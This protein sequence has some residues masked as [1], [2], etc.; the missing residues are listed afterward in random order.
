V[1]E[2]R[3]RFSMRTL[4]ACCLLVMLVQMGLVVAQ[5]SQAAKPGGPPAPP[6]AAKLPGAGA[7]GAPGAAGQQGPP[8]SALGYVPISRPFDNPSTLTQLTPLI[9]IVPECP[10]SQTTVTEIQRMR[11]TA[12]QI[13]QMIEAEVQIMTKR[14][15]YVEQMSSYLNDRIRELNKVKSELAQETHWLEVSSSRIEEL[16]QREKLVR[17]QDVLTC[18]NGDQSKLTGEASM[19]QDIIAKLRAET[20]E[21]QSKIDAIKSQIGS[22]DANGVAPAGS[23]DVASSYF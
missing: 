22:G 14:K 6:P 17:L 7:P 3:S 1:N 8:S 10:V 13:A 5:S 16:A 4:A 20:T 21:V 15:V 23:A 19:K 18:L 9:P 11:Q 2:Q 12:S